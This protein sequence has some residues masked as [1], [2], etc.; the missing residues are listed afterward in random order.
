MLYDK[1]CIHS[2]YKEVK[3]YGRCFQEV[4]PAINTGQGDVMKKLSLC[5][6]LFL[7]SCHA[8]PVSA[9]TGIDGINTV[10]REMSQNPKY[11]KNNVQKAVFSLCQDLIVSNI[12]LA[13]HVGSISAFCSI[14]PYHK[15][16]DTLKS[17][18]AV[19]I[20]KLVK[21]SGGL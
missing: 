6:A 8:V 16:C 18:P 21:D 11:V 14:E 20:L 9:E 12:K 1:V 4:R 15:Q 19:E 3:I 7:A 2:S 10:C 5:L 17:K 13:Y